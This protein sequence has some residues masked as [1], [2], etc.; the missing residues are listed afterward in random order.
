MSLTKKKEKESESKQKAVKY[1]L[2]DW[3][4]SIEYVEDQT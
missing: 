3:L 2:I 4:D 1:W